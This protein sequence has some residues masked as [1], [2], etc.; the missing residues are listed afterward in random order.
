MIDLIVYKT[1]NASVSEILNFLTQCDA[2]FVPPLSNRVVLDQYA[3]KIV[4]KS[5]RFEAWYSDELIGLV[6]SYCNHSE[7]LKAFITNVSVHSAFTRRGVAEKLLQQCIEHAK[8][9][10]IHQICLEVGRDNLSA[11]RLYGRLGFNVSG[12]SPNKVEMIIILKEAI[13]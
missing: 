12:V 11:R 13:T 8:L 7:N 6:A 9:T 10:E 1:N 3:D 5:T 4:Q 2:D